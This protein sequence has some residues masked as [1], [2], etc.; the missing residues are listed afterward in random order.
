MTASVL[1]DSFSAWSAVGLYEFFFEIE[2]VVV[3]SSDQFA[4]PDVPSSDS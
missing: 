2:M 4:F 1:P 3:Y